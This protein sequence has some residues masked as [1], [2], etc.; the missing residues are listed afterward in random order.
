MNILCDDPS[1]DQRVVKLRAAEGS[2]L[3]HVPVYKFAHTVVLLSQF[4]G[5]PGASAG[6]SIVLRCLRIEQG[7][8]PFRGNESIGAAEEISHVTPVDG[9][10]EPDADPAARTD[11]GRYE[12]ALVRRPDHRRLVSERG[13]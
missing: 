7:A 12:E 9:A 3:L 8:E 5:M 6:R 4:L 1:H 11:V 10:V 2:I 13:F